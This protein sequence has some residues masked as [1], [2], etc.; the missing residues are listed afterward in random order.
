VHPVGGEV[1]CYLDLARALGE[2]QPVFG[3]QSPTGTAAAPRGIADMAADYLQ[4]IRAVQPLG[5]YRLAGW[6][7]GGVVAFE[8]ARQLATAGEGVELLAVIDAAA[9][10]AATGNEHDLLS[11]VLLF[12]RDLWGISG[13]RLDAAQLASRDDL[14]RLAPDD[15]LRQLFEE[16][17][18]AGLLPPELDFAPLRRSFER[19][20]A[21]RRALATYAG[22]PYPGAMVLVRGAETDHGAAAGD[23]T[24][25][26][27]QLARGGVALSFSP[28]DH[29]TMVR[30]PQVETLAG[31]LRPHLERI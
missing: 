14:R 10:L 30:R 17:H 9:P 29:Y 26:W 8:M 19:F 18:A 5:P 3:L 25:G 27:G 16:A 24:L 7:M 21:N 13:R 28:G 11:E 1:L 2:H 22:G 4:A 12:A 23:E 6:S 31:Q 20:A 15:L